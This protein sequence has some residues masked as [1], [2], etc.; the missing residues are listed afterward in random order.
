MRFKGIQ[1][2]GGVDD[3]VSARCDD[4][5]SLADRASVVVD[6]FDDFVEQ[7]DVEAIVGEGQLLSRGDTQIW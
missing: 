5:V 2:V 4:A 6:M 7:D 1:S 3:D